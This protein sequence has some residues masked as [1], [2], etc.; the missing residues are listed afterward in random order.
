MPEAYEV[1]V[2]AAL[3]PQWAAL[4]AHDSDRLSKRLN[5][6]ASR[7]STHPA[8]WP[9]GTP[10]GIHRGRHRAIVDELWLLYLLNDEARTV[11]VIGFGR[12]DQ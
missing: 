1:I 3:E 11:N 12:L 4:T 5:R 8:V 2:P 7:A 10:V 6:A 9:L